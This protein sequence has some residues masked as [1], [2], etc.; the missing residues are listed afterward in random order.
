MPEETLTQ[1]T[2][3]FKP[4]LELIPETKNLEATC[5]QANLR[6]GSPERKHFR[7][8]KTPMQRKRCRSV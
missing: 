1:L 7:L 5:P 6:K 4:A 8:L 3:V 2:G